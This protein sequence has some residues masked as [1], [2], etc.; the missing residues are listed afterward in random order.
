[1]RVRVTTIQDLR[2]MAD[3]L[4]D[5]I[6]ERQRELEAIEHAMNVFETNM[7]SGQ[8]HQAG[9]FTAAVKSA[10][11]EILRNEGP[12]HRSEVLNRLED[13]GLMFTHHKN[14]VNTVASFL[15]Q[16]PNVKGDGKGNWDSTERKEVPSEI[17]ET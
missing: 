6:A 7:A 10:I 4:K 5:V 17:N 3:H 13:Q 16:T 8:T 9:S 14:P 15:S 1:M 2:A 11:Q 12:L